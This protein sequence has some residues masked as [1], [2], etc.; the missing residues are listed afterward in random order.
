MCYWHPSKFNIF[1]ACNMRQISA[2]KCISLCY[3]NVYIHETHTVYIYN[4]HIINESNMT[5]NYR[6]AIT[7]AY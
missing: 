6:H 3:N 4:I 1:Y 7:S 5:L 2:Y